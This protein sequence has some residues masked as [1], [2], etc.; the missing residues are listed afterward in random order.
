MGEAVLFELHLHA[1]TWASTDL[2]GHGAEVFQISLKLGSPA[3]PDSILLH[4]QWGNSLLQFTDHLVPQKFGQGLVAAGQEITQ[5]LLLSLRILYPA[6]LRKFVQELRPGNRREFVDEY[7][8]ELLLR[9]RRLQW[10]IDNFPCLLESLDRFINRLAFKPLVGHGRRRHGRQ[11][12]H[13]LGNQLFAIGKAGVRHLAIHLG[14]HD[15][16]VAGFLVAEHEGI[17]TG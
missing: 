15:G 14:I 10:V 2:E 8:G 16:G 13:D 5:P 17:R 12:S 3:A 9:G 6:D 1:G 7:R 11:F 4:L